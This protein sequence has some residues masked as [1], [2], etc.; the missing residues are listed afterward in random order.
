MKHPLVKL[1]PKDGRRVRAGAPWV[2]S[3]EIVMDPA[4][5]A[6]P[7]G[8]IV[9]VQGDDGVV[10]GTGYF[11]AASLIS[12]RILDPKVDTTIDGAFFAAALKRALARREALYDAPYYRLV[13]AEG[14]ALP[15]LA[16]DRFD[17]LCS[18][19]VTTTGMEKLTPALLEGLDEVLAPQTVVL[20]NDTPS[21][22]L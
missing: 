21:R 10:F 7:P 3:N 13:H 5:K 22:A 8:S 12:V 17:D 15:G 6:L 2:F 19:Q 11:N 14:D 4:T 18:V 1:R 20:R 16:I 9:T